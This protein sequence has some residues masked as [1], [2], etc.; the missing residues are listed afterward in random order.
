MKSKYSKLKIFN[1]KDKLDSLPEESEKILAPVHIRIKPT[2]VCNHHCWYCAYHQ[3]DF[4]LGQ[5]MVMKDTIPEQK[6]MEIIDDIADMGV[7]AVTFSGGGEP[8]YYRHINQALKKLAE[9]NIAFAAITNGSFLQEETAELF[10][11]YGTWLRI[12]IDGWDDES[13]KKYRNCKDGEYTRVIENIK[14]LK[15]KDCKCLVGISLILDKH[16]VVHIE[17]QLQLYK[18]IGVDSV[19]LSAVIVSNDSKENNAYHAPFYKQTKAS[20]KKVK[21]QLEDE[22]FEIFDAYHELEENFNKDYSWCPY[23]QIT[24]VIGAD[25]NVYSCHDKAYNFET[26]MLGSIKE[27]SF[28]EFWFSDKRNFFKINPSRDCGHHCCVN[29]HNKIILEFLD[30]ESGHSDFV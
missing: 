23:C 9:K 26:G 6:M 14:R 25:L 17:E 22:S 18:S 27:Q 8:L 3:D 19:K 11:K 5:D 10:A 2:N 4:Q 1:F 28:K 16:N 12:S 20:I 7:K 13:Y 15:Q 29:T 30:L 24:P 21:E